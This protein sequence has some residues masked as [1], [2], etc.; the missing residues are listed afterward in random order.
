[1]NNEDPALPSSLP[2]REEL[3]ALTQE[4]R[5]QNEALQKLASAFA[6]F[7]IRFLMGIVTGL[8]TVIGATVVV[9]LLAFL[10]RPLANAEVIGPFIGD[11]IES[12]EDGRPMDQPSSNDVSEQNQNG[13]GPVDPDLV[14]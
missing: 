6:S 8:G 12:V 1:M 7:K 4:L 11:I 5:T 9:S 10:L 14:P 2:S 3:L 13:N